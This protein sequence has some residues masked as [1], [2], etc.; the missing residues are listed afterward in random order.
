MIPK[1]F[2]EDFTAIVRG[3]RLDNTLNTLI[4]EIRMNS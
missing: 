3:I 2:E 4:V 1:I